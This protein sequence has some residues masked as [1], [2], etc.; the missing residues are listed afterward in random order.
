[1]KTS[2]VINWRKLGNE[3][4]ALKRQ[5]SEGRRTYRGLVPLND[6]QRKSRQQKADWIMQKMLGQVTLL[7]PNHNQPAIATVDENG[8]FRYLPLDKTGL[9]M[10]EISTLRRQ[11]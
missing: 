9:T 1:M 7:Y 8:E 10:H 5:L 2:A 11:G 3:Y 4:Q 6:A